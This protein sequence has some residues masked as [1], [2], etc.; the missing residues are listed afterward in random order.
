MAFI[1]GQGT[2]GG[3]LMDAGFGL[4]GVLMVLSAT[5]AFSMRGR[6]VTT[7]TAPGRSG[8]LP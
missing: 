7:R 1:V 5:M 8:C 6:D 3:T 2:I 4:Y